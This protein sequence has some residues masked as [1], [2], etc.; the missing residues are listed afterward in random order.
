MDRK[1]PRAHRPLNHIGHS[2]TRD[3][4][5]KGVRTRQKT[6]FKK[7]AENPNK[8][9]YPIQWTANK[10]R[11]STKK[12]FVKK[13]DKD[14]PLNRPCRRYDEDYFN[15]LTIPTDNNELGMP[16][17]S[18]EDGSAIGLR[19]LPSEEEPQEPKQPES[20]IY[21]VPEGN[22]LIE[23]S[24]FMELI[25]KSTRDHIQLGRCDNIEWDVIDF[26]PWGAF[27]SVI[28]ACK[29]CDYKSDRTKLFEEVPRPEGVSGR[30]AATGNLQILSAL[31]DME[32]GVSKAIL[33]FASIGLRAGSL[34]GMQKM[35]CKVSD[36]TVKLNQENMEHLRDKVKQVLVDRGCKLTDRASGSSDAKYQG[37]M[38]SSQKTP[39]RPAR[40]ATA[41]FTE[42]L[43]RKQYVLGMVH[44]N[45][46]CHK[47]SMLKG[48]DGPIICGDGDKSHARCT[49][50]MLPES[51][52]SENKMSKVLAQEMQQ[53]GLTVSHICTD[54]DARGAEGFQEVYNKVKRTEEEVFKWSKDPWH[55]SR[56]MRNHVLRHDFSP[57]AFGTKAD[58]TAWKAIE[59]KD[60]RKAL[61]LDLPGRV[62]L[63]LQNARKHWKGDTEKI[64][65]YCPIL[66]DKII[67]CY[68][69]NHAACLSS[70]LAKLTGCNGGKKTWFK[71]SSNLKA[72]GIS[73]LVLDK[74]DRAF[75]KDA[76]G[77]KLGE[78]DIQYV[79]GRATSSR[80]EGVNR[81][82]SVSLPN[83]QQWS[84]T[85]GGRAASA[86]MRI[87]NGY[88]V[89]TK[90][91]HEALN[92]LLPPSSIG[93]RIMK[94]YQLQRNLRRR[95]QKDPKTLKRQ[96][97]IQ[98]VRRQDY[99]YQRLKCTNK[100]EYRKHQL[101]RAI[102]IVKRTLDKESV[103]LKEKTKS[104]KRGHVPQ[105][106]GE[107]EERL[108]KATVNLENISVVVERHERRKKRKAE[109]T[110]EKRRKAQIERNK[111]KREGRKKLPRQVKHDH[112]Y[113]TY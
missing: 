85:S 15:I 106:A 32:I 28:L 34:S 8:K 88:D 70:P 33:L 78:K 12:Q 87:N 102:D 59:R 71:T 113:N 73:N 90:L 62:S 76:A 74:T 60:C 13:K 11:K 17:A 112:G 95:I 31:Q 41:T 52:M 42:N 45:Q 108:V 35:A 110:S 72:Q 18:G 44:M 10:S 2:R 92:C 23:K 64:A 75:M 97:A 37:V 1:K 53:S 81:A 96:I 57:D 9:K 6:M 47:G 25:N 104:L 19:P 65:K 107:D 29:T 3:Y 30:L 48:K 82:L 98:A 51:Q 55:L 105:P 5:R 83:N 80:N 103:R 109:R 68:E 111:L 49:A 86:I 89:A 43:T 84:R 40:Q 38:K 67:T 50:N 69:G 27:S 4:G 101:D 14:P 100:E 21:N 22:I 91:K 94:K 58:G 46:A 39:G 20:R 16:D 61:A 63:T 36:A 24:R 26:D 93:Y 7:G 66:A 56:N 77:L 54:S 79:S 99:Y